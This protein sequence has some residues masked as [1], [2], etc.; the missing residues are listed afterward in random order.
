[1][2]SSTPKVLHTLCG[3]PDECST[4][5]TRGSTC[6]SRTRRRRGGPRRRARHQDPPGA[7][8]GL[9]PTAVRRAS[10]CSDAAPA[11][12]RA[13]GSRPSRTS[14]ST[15]RSDVLVLPGDTPLLRARRTVAALAPPTRHAEAA[16]TLLTSELD[17]PTGYG[18]VVRS[19]RA[20]RRSGAPHRRAALDATDAGHA[21]RDQRVASDCFR[22]SLLAGTAAPQPRERA[23]RVLP[24]RRRRGAGQ[25]GPPGRRGAGDGERDA[26]RQRPRAARAVE[27]GAPQ[28]HQPQLAAQRGHDAV[29]PARR[30]SSMSRFGSVATSRSPGDDPPGRDL[31][32]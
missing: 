21:S 22:R 2:R 17:D 3:G 28:P 31:D 10:T 4:S 15:T 14:P 32:R 1:M 29:D 24:D 23:G 12:R 18:R 7:G 13:S 27:R 26:R 16:A 25:H 19:P 8:A 5:S 20:G 6:A 30:R 9:G 11:T